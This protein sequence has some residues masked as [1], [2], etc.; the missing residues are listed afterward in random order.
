VEQLMHDVKDKVLEQF[1]VELEPEVK[2]IGE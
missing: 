1:G 2:I